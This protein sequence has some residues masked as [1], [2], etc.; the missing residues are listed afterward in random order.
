MFRARLP[1]Q[2]RRKAASD[3]DQPQAEH[4][5][6]GAVQN[7]IED[8]LLYDI[9]A[10]DPDVVVLDL[11]DAVSISSASTEPLGPSA[12]A[13]EEF[14]NRVAAE[15]ERLQSAPRV[16]LELNRNIHIAE[17][18]RA[19]FAAVLI[20]LSDKSVPEIEDMLMNIQQLY[21]EEYKQASIGAAL[22]QLTKG[23]NSLRKP[24]PT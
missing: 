22:N 1:V 11:S 8:G 13:L 18:K 2:Q 19:A 23:F 20:S 6:H 15:R 9:E 12:R 17:Q 5:I 24:S 10:S 16:I 21:P 7:E 4:E 14:R 3:D